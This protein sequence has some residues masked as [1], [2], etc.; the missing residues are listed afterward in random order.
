M[1][2]L[3]GPW[4]NVEVAL[5]VLLTDALSLEDGRAGTQRPSELK[6]AMPFVLV[7]RYGGGDDGT[8][9]Y[10][11]IGVEVFASTYR[12]GTAL[13]EAS[14]QVLLA[15]PHVITVPEDDD[16]PEHRVVID[17][18]ETGEAPVEAPY[19]ADDVRRFTA[20]YTV[21]TRRRAA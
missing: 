5:T 14:R 8:T 15:A 17:R 19:G 2:T 12:E 7:Y 18:V 20:T 21:H 3:L 11:K 13:A 4:P 1:G 6:A 9:D 10:P 16:E